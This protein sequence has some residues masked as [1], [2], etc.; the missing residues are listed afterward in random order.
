MAK[1]RAKHL[2]VLN[3][4]QVDF[5]TI[6]YSKL[7]EHPEPMELLIHKVEIMDIYSLMA[8]HLVGFTVS[9]LED[10]QHCLIVRIKSGLRHGKQYNF[11]IPLDGFRYVSTQQAVKMR[12]KKFIFKYEDTRHVPPPPYVPPYIPPPPPAQVTVRSDSIKKVLCVFRNKQTGEMLKAE[13]KGLDTRWGMRI[14]SLIS[15]MGKCTCQVAWRM[16]PQKYLPVEDI[17]VSYRDLENPGAVTLPL[18][19]RFTLYFVKPGML[20]FFDITPKGSRPEEESDDAIILQEEVDVNERVRR[21]FLEA[22]KRGAVIN[23]D[24]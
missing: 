6:R 2:G 11:R 5:I 10:S 22:E 9:T 16:T 13:M 8:G 18:K 12:Y 17:E 1:S 23:L 3:E 24:E 15:S 14:T 4:K 19:D 20:F 21:E 7:L